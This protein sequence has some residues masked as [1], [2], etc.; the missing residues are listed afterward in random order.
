M[1]AVA[2]NKITRGVC[3]WLGKERADY[4]FYARTFAPKGNCLW[5]MK[6]ALSGLRYVFILILCVQEWKSFERSRG[7]HR[8]KCES[9][10]FF[11]ILENNGKIL[12]ARSGGIWDNIFMRRAK[13][14]E[15]LGN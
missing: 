14:N 8:V 12:A 10:T 13:E 6:F 7:M 2:Q 15:I 9:E 3:V 5:E 11:F 4:A 1:A